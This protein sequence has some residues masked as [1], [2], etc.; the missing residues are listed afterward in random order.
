MVRKPNSN[1]SIYVV[2]KLKL[3]IILARL[4]L[5]QGLGALQFT[6]GP[7]SSKAH[8]QKNKQTQSMLFKQCPLNALTVDHTIKNFL[9]FPYFTNIK[10]RKK[11]L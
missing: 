6:R 1:L 4:A 3:V 7:S 2:L 11:H 10:D 8:L 9:V 5:S